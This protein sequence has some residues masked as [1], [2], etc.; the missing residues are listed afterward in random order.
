M[1]D[2][3]SIITKGLEHIGH[4]SSMAPA[5]RSGFLLVGSA[6]AFIGFVI[7]GM[8]GVEYTPPPVAGYPAVYDDRVLGFTGVFNGFDGPYKCHEMLVSIIAMAV[9]GLA[10]NVMDFS[11]AWHGLTTIGK[12]GH[13]LYHGS[14][15]F[16][17]V[18]S[19][20]YFIWQF[21]SGQTPEAIRVSFADRLGG[22][23]A[24]V[25]ASHYVTASLGLA[26]IIAFVGMLIALVGI[27][28][29]TFG[30]L[31]G[32]AAASIVVII[33]VAPRAKVTVAEF[34][35]TPAATCVLVPTYVENCA[36]TNPK[37][38]LKLLNTASGTAGCRFALTI[39][40]G[41]HSRKQHVNVT[42]AKAAIGTI[43]VTYHTY[44]AHG[45]HNVVVTGYATAGN[46]ST[47]QWTWE[48]GFTLT[49]A[50]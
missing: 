4:K 34:A 15:V 37:I 12:V 33:I 17:G 25:N 21:R 20:A 26:T 28:P 7:P 9:L 39:D 27:L 36:S 10:V 8:Y 43:H 45:F 2:G 47:T 13:G 38:E 44:Q 32:L 11:S 50:Q 14:G 6:I 18:G 41:D 3:A 40:W 5:K 42:G 30:I 22:G 29:K 1:S 24:A 31:S 48:P 46:C 35:P 16:A 19:I 23:T 49:A